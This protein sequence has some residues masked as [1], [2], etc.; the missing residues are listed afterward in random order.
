MKLDDLA[1]GE[2]ATHSHIKDAKAI[3]IKRMSLHTFSWVFPP[4][5]ISGSGASIDEEFIY[6]NDWV[7]CDSSGKTKPSYSISKI[8]ENKG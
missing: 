4:T 8:Y 1:V 3:A 6:C 7:R 5:R 2:F